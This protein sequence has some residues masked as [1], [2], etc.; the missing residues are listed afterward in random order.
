MGKIPQY[1]SNKMVEGLRIRSGRFE[2]QKNLEIE[3]RFLGIP[4]HSLV[5]VPSTLFYTETVLN[6]HVSPAFVGIFGAGTF[7]RAGS[8]FM[9]TGLWL[10]FPGLSVQPS[11]DVR[12]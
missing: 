7:Y 11:L 4:A 1:L 2:D 8:T 3:P 6:I 12:L 5:T 10:L 9:W